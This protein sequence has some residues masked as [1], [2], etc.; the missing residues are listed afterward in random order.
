MPALAASPAVQR[1]GEVVQAQAFTY[2]TL[3]L[4]L[5]SYS[6][7]VGYSMLFE[8]LL[9]YELT[10]ARNMTWALRPGL[11]E[12]WEQADPKTVV[13]H[14]RRG[15]RFHDGSEFNAAVA[16]WNLER[17]RDHPKSFGKPYLADVDAVEVPD[18]ATLRVR[19]TKPSGSLPFRLCEANYAQMGMLSKAAF[20]KL[21]EAGIARTPV[22]TGP[23]RFKQ[24]VTDDRLVLERYPDY[25]R[26]GAD[27]RPL[28][29]IDAF[30]SRY[31]PDLTV[32]V[33]DLQSG[34]LTAAEN[35]PVNQLSVLR[36]NPRLRLIEWPWAGPSYFHMGMNIYKPPFNDVQVRRAAVHGIDREGMATALGFGFAQPR[37]Y[38]YW[39]PGMPG[40][41]PSLPKYEYDPDRVKRLLSEAGHPNGIET[42]L[43]VIQ[44]EP[45]GTIGQFAAEMWSKVGIKTTLRT[46]ER[47]TWITLVKSM[48]FQA[49]FSRNTPQQADPVQL[50]SNI[51]GGAPYNWSG[52]RD[53]VVD[54]LM[55]QADQTLEPKTRA[56]LYRRV[57]LR[58]QEQAYLGDGYTVPF[59]YVIDRRL[60]GLVAQYGIPDFTQV[61][62][63]R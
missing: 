7:P 17:L 22:G 39:A 9:R 4:H 58:M 30:V 62:L 32:A 50:Q 33:P 44:R 38:P 25:W 35:V 46:Q 5:S 15:V 27:G 6:L 10:D 21:G 23:M 12:T 2:P 43:L 3:D 36:A 52:F 45:E 20:D 56:G 19:L 1:G 34:Q 28:P 29:Y 40:F 42:E 55:R 18:P 57:L 13:F 54:T 48:N 41:D 63:S 53:A 26:N 59:N 8:Y 37:L 60:N 11:A 47:L 24:W 49:M 61:W 31:I 51:M 14:L 16:K